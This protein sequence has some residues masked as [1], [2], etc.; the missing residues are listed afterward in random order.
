MPL[1][2]ERELG[3]F[4]PT[5]TPAGA[6]DVLTIE[7]HPAVLQ[8]PEQADALPFVIT[9]P[10]QPEVGVRIAPALSH[11]LLLCREAG[12]IPQTLVQVGI[13]ERSAWPADLR[14]WVPA[15]AKT[16]TFDEVLSAP[17][18]NLDVVSTRYVLWDRV[19]ST[20][21]PVD[22]AGWPKA[23]ANVLTAG[24]VWYSLEVLP[25]EMAAHWTYTFFP[26]LWDWARAR[27]RD[28]HAL[29]GEA[30]AAGFK[31]QVK[32]Q[33]F[34]QPVGLKVAAEFAQRQDR[35]AGAAERSGLSAGLL[36]VAN[37]PTRARR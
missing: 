4:V 16:A 30:Q 21:Q 9:N 25:T 2:S 31:P 6:T 28:M 10:L 15:V 12:V 13:T 18:N 19:F 23:L 34:Y 26:E 27:T 24:G 11:A 3:V 5:W 29:F 17:R 37:G 22:P 20:S 1:L 7:H 35:P 8:T 36:E 14:K 33:V 32:R